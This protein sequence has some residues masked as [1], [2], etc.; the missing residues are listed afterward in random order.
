MTYLRRKVIKQFF[1]QIGNIYIT[2]GMIKRKN[3]KREKKN[4][5]KAI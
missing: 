1:L 2:F 5:E 4:G 3:E